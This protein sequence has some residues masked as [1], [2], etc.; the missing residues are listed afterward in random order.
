MTGVLSALEMLEAFLTEGEPTLRVED[1]KI[2][3][4]SVERLRQTTTY[5]LEQALLTAIDPGIA[6]ILAEFDEYVIIDRQRR[7]LIEVVV[8]SD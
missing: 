1:L 8:G 2:D 6:G 4:L 5:R 3:E 7:V